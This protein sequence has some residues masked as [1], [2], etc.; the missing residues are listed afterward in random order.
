MAGVEHMGVWW[1]LGAWQALG[2]WW[3]FGMLWVLGDLRVGIP[4]PGAG[5]AWRVFMS[6]MSSFVDGLHC[7]CVVVIVVVV[8]VVIGAKP[9]N[10]NKR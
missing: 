3:T 4:C 8:V 6:S 10:E 2:V 1:E 5:G 9:K 7:C